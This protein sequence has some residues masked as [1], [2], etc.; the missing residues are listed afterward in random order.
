MVVAAAP[1]GGPQ[2][3]V[4]AGWEDAISMPEVGAPGSCWATRPTMWVLCQPLLL[5]MLLLAVMKRSP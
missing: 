1:G 3:A 2:R 5:L 4:P